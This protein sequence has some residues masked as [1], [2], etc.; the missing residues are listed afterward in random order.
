MNDIFVIS[1]II[2]SILCWYIF[3][4][5]KPKRKS[6]MQKWNGKGRKM[7]KRQS[8]SDLDSFG[9]PRGGGVQRYSNGKISYHKPK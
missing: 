5:Y 1:V 7:T 3:K 4:Y 8:N 2:I 6:V 9:R